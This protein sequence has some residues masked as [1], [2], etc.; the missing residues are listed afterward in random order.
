M[1]VFVFK[2]LLKVVECVS[3]NNNDYV[4]KANDAKCIWYLFHPIRD[5]SDSSILI[6][7]ED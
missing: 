7:T 3:N 1:Q 6:H 4:V 2:I 5:K